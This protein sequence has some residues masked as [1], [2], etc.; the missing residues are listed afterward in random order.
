MMAK[1]DYIV[2]LDF[3]PHGKPSDRKAEPV[4]QGIGEKFLNLLEVAVKD[5][6]TMK[7]NDRI[8]VGDDKREQVKYIRGRIGYE[9]LTNYAKNMVTEIVRDL[10]NKDEKRFINF[11]NKAGPVTTRLHSLELLPGIGKKHMWDIL[12]E[13]RKRP[14]EDFKDLQVRVPM[15]P[16]PKKMVVKRI[17]EDLEGKDRYRLFVGSPLL[18]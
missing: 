16:D 14:F 4:A 13:R 10:V 12:G 2:V 5:G 18:Q 8:Y 17:I 7:A 9:D 1:D 11:F 6:V 15:L 3:L